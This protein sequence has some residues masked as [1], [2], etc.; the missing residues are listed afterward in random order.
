MEAVSHV[1]ETACRTQFFSVALPGVSQQTGTFGEGHR[2]FLAT[3][4]GWVIVPIFS[5]AGDRSTDPNTV[6][7]IA[8]MTVAIV[9]FLILFFMFILLRNLRNSTSIFHG[10][11]SLLI[12]LM[13]YA[14]RYLE[15]I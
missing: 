6:A 12:F 14:V 4:N 8:I 11:T 13:K 15:N 7:A 5:D 3:F 2:L 9:T 10:A 1:L